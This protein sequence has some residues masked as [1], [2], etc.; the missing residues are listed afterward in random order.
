MAAILPYPGARECGVRRAAW[1]VRR[2]ACD[3][4]RAAWGVG[5]RRVR[6]MVSDK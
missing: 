3:V 6:G 5:V 1:G 4:G 2:G